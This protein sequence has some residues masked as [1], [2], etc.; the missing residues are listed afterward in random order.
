MAMKLFIPAVGYRIKLTQPWTFALYGESR[1][2]TMF[3]EHKLNIG[4]L[5][6]PWGSPLKSVQFTIASGTVLEVDRVYVRNANKDKSGDDDYD[7]VTFRVIDDKKRKRRFWAKLVDVNT[8]EYELPPDHT[9]GKD[10]AKERSTQRKKLDPQKICDLVASACNIAS[11]RRRGPPPQWFSR[12]VINDLKKLEAEYIRLFEPY[13]RA[14]YDKARAERRALLELEI[15][16]GK[17]SLPVGIASQVKCVDDLN[18]FGLYENWIG[19]HEFVLRSATWDYILI[20]HVLGRYGYIGE[21]TF[22]KMPDGT[23]CRTFRPASPDKLSIHMKDSPDISHM[24]VKVYTDVE[25][26]D[27]IKIESGIDVK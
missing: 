2:K 8:I 10:A 18:R 1:N 11:N 3:E 9:A 22:T 25:D 7:S 24:W 16:T 19:D 26:F 13:E 27:I 14:K 15:A 21:R 5:S 12:D 20:Y 4:E 6:V 17:L 23:R